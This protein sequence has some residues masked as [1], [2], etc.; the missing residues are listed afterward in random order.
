[1]ENVTADLLTIFWIAA[2]IVGIGL[3]AAGAERRIVIYYDGTDM[4]VSAFAVIFP[5]VAWVLSD[6]NIFESSFL[7]WMVHWLVS[8]AIGIAGLSLMVANFKSAIRHNRSIA[9]GLLV[10]LFKIVFLALTVIVIFGQISKIT[11]E[12]TSFG[13]AVFA[14]LLLVICYVVAKAMINGPEVYVAKGWELPE[15]MAKAG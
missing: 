5:L 9:L 15:T 2:A 11:D 1:M 4:A 8:P 13:E 6:S 7:N 12:R 14:A 3:L 10:G